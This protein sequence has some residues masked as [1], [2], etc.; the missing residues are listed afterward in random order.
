MAP[1][2]ILQDILF[3][4]TSALTGENVQDV[5]HTLAQRILNKAPWLTAP[6]CISGASQ[7]SPCRLGGA[8]GCQHAGRPV[9]PHCS[10]SQPHP[11]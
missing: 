4:E 11:G 7:L 8:E 5:F 9:G 10:P 1:V 3:L 6:A 2:G